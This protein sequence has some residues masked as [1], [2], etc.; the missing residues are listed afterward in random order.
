MLIFVVC[1]SK[2]RELEM[3][4]LFTLAAAAGALAGVQ[5]IATTPAV[6]GGYCGSYGYAG[7][8]GYA[9]GYAAYGGCCPRYYQ[10]VGYYQPVVTQWVARPLGYYR[11]VVGYRPYF[12]RGYRW[13]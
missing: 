12:R 7:Y 2:V 13:R 6:A 1:R 10:G 9:Y 3:R 4:K 11:P 8:Y 5:A